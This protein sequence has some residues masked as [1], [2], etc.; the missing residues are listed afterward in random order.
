MSLHSWSRRASR[1]AFTTAFFLLA[2]SPALARTMPAGYEYV[3]P[4]PGSR[5]LSP[6]NNII[7]RTGQVLNRG[8]LHQA[9]IV[10]EGSVS[11]IHEGTL[12]LADDRETVLFQPDRPFAPGEEVR[13]RVVPRERGNAPQP[14]P[15][16]DFSFTV[17]AGSPASHTAAAERAAAADFESNAPLVSKGA[18]VRPAPYDDPPPDDEP[19]AEGVPLIVTNVNERPAAQHLFVAPFS[20]LF[21]EPGYLYVLDEYRKPVFRRKLPFGATDFKAQPNGWFT[22]WTTATDGVPRYYVLDSRAAVVDSIEGGNGYVADLHELE[23]LP[24]GHLLLMCYDPETVRMDSIVPGG[25]P[26]A[27]AIGLV[28]QELDAQRRV[29]FQWRSWDAFAISDVVDPSIPLTG[30]TI[31]YV[32]G[33]ALSVDVDGNLIVSSRHM[34]EIT[35]IDRRT[36]EVLWRFGG[37]ASNNQFTISGDPRGFSHQHHVRVLPNGHFTLFDNGN[38]VSP[39]ES[40]ALE[41]ELDENAK[42]ARLVWE[43]VHSPILKGGALGSV[44]RFTDGGTLIC[45][46]ADAATVKFTELDATGHVVYDAGFNSTGFNTYR[47]LEGPWHTRRIA[48]DVDRLDFGAVPAGETVTRE[49]RVSNPGPDSLLIN[50]VSTGGDS[51]FHATRPEARDLAPGESMTIPVDFVAPASGAAHGKLYVGTSGPTDLLLHEVVLDGSSVGAAALARRGP[52]TSV[53]AAVATDRAKPEATVS[54]SL[55]QAS[56][57]EVEVFS[58]TGRRMATLARGT[59]AAGEHAAVWDS[60]GA[61]SGVYFCRVRASGATLTRKFAVVH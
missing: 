54:F 45:W 31:D 35:K 22:Y 14:L 3:S 55:P 60:H 9:A 1:A 21:Q 27:T 41:Y 16:L 58:V 47:A 23:V 11:G 19:P 40:R 44:Q 12:D 7:L 24:D 59:F 32:H 5:F 51:A 18:S 42:T 26:D 13:V 56:E 28:V 39:N 17:S 36:G 20:S 15:A 25:K 43:Y 61:P 30:Q 57:V 34:N 52:A 4:V 8:Q 10:V 6:G 33:N 49:V 38:N 37:R 29:V 48:T 50:S 53:E 46:G 2:A